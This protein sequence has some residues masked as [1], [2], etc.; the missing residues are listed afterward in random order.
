MQLSGIRSRSTTQ[1]NVVRTK[2]RIY[3]NTIFTIQRCAASLIR[4]FRD[5]QPTLRKWC[6]YVK[7][8]IS[9]FNGRKK[10]RLFRV[11]LSCIWILAMS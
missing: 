10:A 9:L 5:T 7:T 1:Q 8:C 4:G 6:Y 3:K 2:V 11:G